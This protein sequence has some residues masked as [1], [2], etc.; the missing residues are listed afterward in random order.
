VYSIG[1]CLHLLS[2]CTSPDPELQWRVGEG[3]EGKGE[4]GRLG[5]GVHCSTLSTV[6]RTKEASQA[7]VRN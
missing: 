4:E 6:M 5:E 2:K 7:E 1:R 3:E